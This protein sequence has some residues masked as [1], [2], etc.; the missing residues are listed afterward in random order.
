M[1]RRNSMR[2]PVDVGDE[3]DVTIEA[4]GAKGDGVAKVQGFVLFIPNVKEG[5]RCKVKVT[6]VLKKVGFA[7]K[8]GEAG[9]EEP[10]VKESVTREVSALESAPIPEPDEP[11]DTEDFGEEEQ[12]EYSDEESF[13]ED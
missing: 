13:E 9:P 4:V 6:K 8:I 5:E 12:E 2:P 11:E 3:V 10:G 1:Q 7:E